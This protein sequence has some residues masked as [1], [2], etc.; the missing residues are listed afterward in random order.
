MDV[1]QGFL[2]INEPKPFAKIGRQGLGDGRM[3]LI[4]KLASQGPKAAG[5]ETQAGELVRRRIIRN[6]AH[7]FAAVFSLQEI[8][9][10]MGDLPGTAVSRQFAVYGNFFT[11]FEAVLHP[12]HTLKPNQI[13]G[14]GAIA[15]L[16][17]EPTAP[18][19][20][21]EKF[22]VNDFAHEHDLRFL[23]AQLRNL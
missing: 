20:G 13:Q 22:Q 6:D 4:E 9:L 16:A 23:P 7:A 5:V 10:W 18:P 12:F 3:R 14:P 2:A 8:D 15:E 19:F 1:E 11:D 17:P 21:L